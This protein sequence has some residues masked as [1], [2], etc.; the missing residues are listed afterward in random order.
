MTVSVQ[1]VMVLRKYIAVTF[2]ILTSE[3][4]YSKT[5]HFLHEY[6]KKSCEVLNNLAGATELDLRLLWIA[7]TSHGMAR[8]D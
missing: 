7:I 3:G 8:R 6:L 5:Q 2:M 1:C 4:L